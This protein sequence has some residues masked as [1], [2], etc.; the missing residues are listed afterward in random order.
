MARNTR[1]TPALVIAADTFVGPTLENAF[2]GP[3]AP[4][5]NEDVPPALEQTETP[6]SDAPS[7]DVSAPDSAQDDQQQ[8]VPPEMTDAQRALEAAAIDAEASGRAISDVLADMGLNADGTKRAIKDVY[9]GPMVALKTARLRY[10]S[11]ANGNLC[12]G[13]AIAQAFGRMKPA[14]VVRAAMEVLDERRNKYAHLN[15]GQQ[16]MNYRN[17]VRQAIKRG[18][19]NVDAVLDLIHT[20]ADS[21]EDAAE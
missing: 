16:S 5:A 15:Q 20:I 9:M 3:I 4:V 11:A 17:R 14:D 6:V 1:K 13:D 12:N 21:I 7:Q 10:V 8:D 2:V 19:L 18:D